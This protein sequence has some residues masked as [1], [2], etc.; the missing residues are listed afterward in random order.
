M[1]GEVAYVDT[2]AFVKLIV[3][4]PESDKLRERFQHWPAR[5][6]SMLLRTEAV[7]AVRPHGDDAVARARAEMRRVRLL[8][9]TS[10]VLDAAADLPRPLRSLDA[11]HIASALRLG[12]DLGVVV[13]Y[14]QRMTDA[15]RS[16]GL[17]VE[18]PA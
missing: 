4:E 9:I 15:A 18:A 12:S 17:P 13:T 6:S 10:R 2:S 16:L 11:I 8:Q 3:D 1:S 5:V 7:R 14:D